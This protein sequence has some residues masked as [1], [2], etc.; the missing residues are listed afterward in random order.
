MA[1]RATVYKTG[2]FVQLSLKLS[3]LHIG[4]L[5]WLVCSETLGT[6]FL[7]LQNYQKLVP[8]GGNE[9]SSATVLDVH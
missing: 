7:G 9:F 6:N 8:L 2:L 5:R 1:Y 4:A 3:Y